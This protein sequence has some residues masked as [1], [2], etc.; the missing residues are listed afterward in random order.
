MAVMLGQLKMY[1]KNSLIF[2]LSLVMILG[3]DLKVQ[4]TPRVIIAQSEAQTQLILEEVS[5][6]PEEKEK[7]TLALQELEKAKNDF[8]PTLQSFTKELQTVVYTQNVGNLAPMQDASIKLDKLIESH[9]YLKG[10]LENSVLNNEAKIKN[11]SQNIGVILERISKVVNPF[12]TGLDSAKVKQVQEYLGFFPRRNINPQFY[13]IYGQTTQDEIKNFTQDN[14]NK[15][16]IQ[17]KQL[18]D[19][20]NQEIQR[21]EKEAETAS[22]QKLEEK[23]NQLEAE[24][25]SLKSEIE[26]IISSPNSDVF[27]FVMGIVTLSLLGYLLFFLYKKTEKK[28][29]NPTRIYN[30]TTNDLALIEEEMYDKI[31]Q[32]FKDQMRLIESR[33]KVLEGTSSFPKNIPHFS[34]SSAVDQ[35]LRIIATREQGIANLDSESTPKIINP[36]DSLVNDYNL[37]LEELEKNALEVAPTTQDF[38]PQEDNTLPQEII[39]QKQLKGQYWITKVDDFYY[40]VPKLNILITKLSY[41]SLQNFFECYSYK[42]GISTK[43]QLLKPARVCVVEDEQEWEFIQKGV[44]QFV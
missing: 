40:L 37:G 38:T 9:Q 11:N 42:P 16:G 24:N 1:K 22:L 41:Q 23:L 30:L 13:G 21:I 3:G 31:A 36:Y 32:Q 5:F 4:S 35:K 18:K 29:V 12:K 10:L 6:S 39:F 34:P 20:L 19:N 27:T 2:F 43:I 8:N 26:Q 25:N 17:I 28:A 33:F 14:Y 44:I 15:L 7:I